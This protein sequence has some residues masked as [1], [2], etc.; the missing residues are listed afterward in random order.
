MA[1]RRSPDQSHVDEAAASDGG[2]A[3]GKHER[4]ERENQQLRADAD[5]LRI[6]CSELESKLAERTAQRDALAA[7]CAELEGQRAALAQSRNE[8]VEEQRLVQKERKKLELQ[9]AMLRTE[10]SGQQG[11]ANP[12]RERLAKLDYQLAWERASLHAEKKK[13]EEARAKLEQEAQALELEKAELP[14]SNRSAGSASSAS[15]PAAA[16]VARAPSVSRRSAAAAGLMRQ[17][18]PTRTKASGRLST[19]RLQALLAAGLVL[20]VALAAVLVWRLRTQPSRTAAAREP[21]LEKN[22][23]D[24]QPPDTSALAGAHPQPGARQARADGVPALEDSSDAMEPGLQDEA[25]EADRALPGDEDAPERAPEG[26]RDNSEPVGTLPRRS[27]AAVTDKPASAPS[28]PRPPPAT[29]TKQAAPPSP[30]P[31]SPSPSK[32]DG[33]K[34][35]DEPSTSSR[36]S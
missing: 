22:R 31:R 2:A 8:L 13:L 24:M 25:A 3:G 16:R 20:A 18:G 14:A 28:S 15:G 9:I 19:K 7:S 35:I 32:T 10:D 5:S 4:L 12:S 1:K 6:Q 26:A 30:E 29:P 33:N 34:K 17:A 27:S 11:A 36:V 21:M 23:P